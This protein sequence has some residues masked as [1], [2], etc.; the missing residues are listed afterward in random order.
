MNIYRDN[1]A[2]AFH[3][4]NPMMKKCVDLKERGYQEKDKYDYA[5]KDFEDAMDSYDKV[6]EIIGEI[7]GTVLAEN[8]HEVDV[9]GPK[10]ENNRVSYAPGTQINHD[11]L[12]QAGVY[13]IALPRQ[14]GGLNFPI[15][16]YVMSAEIISRAD[17][18]FANIWGLQDCA[19][20]IYEFASVEI[21]N[22]FLPR[23]NKGATCSMDLTEPD[24]GS[25]LQ[26]VQ[27]SATFDE[28]KQ[29]W[30]LNGVKRFITNGDAEIKLVLARSEAGTKDGRG[31]SYFV[32]DKAWGGVKVRRIENK[33][34]I[35]GSPTCEL[36]FDNAPAKL[37]GDRKMGLIKYVMTLMNAAR[38]GVA[39]QSVGLSEEAYRQAYK[40]ATER[41]QFGKAIINFEPVKEMLSLIRAK[42]DAARTLLYETARW[43]DLT[44]TYSFMQNDGIKL[45]PEERADLKAAQKNADML[46]PILKMFSSEFANQCA[47]DAV[48]VHGGTGF[49]KDFPVERLYRD[50]RIL[51]IYEGTSQLQVVAA[52]RNITNGSIE[53]YISELA[54]MEVSAEFSAAKQRIAQMT[55][56]LTACIEKVKS[57]NSD[58]ALDFNARRLVEIAGHIV[59]SHLMLLDASRNSE[60]FKKSA[61]F[62]LQYA[63]SEVAKHKMYIDTFT[64]DILA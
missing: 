2:L 37:V 61:L 19:E 53:K 25:D 11:T 57:F 62:Y 38:L 56:S 41:E 36:V 48:Q 52:I 63:F 27:L 32:Y 23:I 49:M 12:T 8:A 35:K 21:K 1:E 7:A 51:T 3:L 64:E 59:M 26:S 60:M 33:M 9:M 29:M 6:M 16:P 55:E 13:G 20:T 44:K 40:Y 58:A 47:Y 30:M 39:A 17:A 14:Y 18:G 34:G 10:L 24:A 15:V 43:V 54:A 4:N 31:L 22:E 46:T 42:T 45:S 28:N 50:A 5:P